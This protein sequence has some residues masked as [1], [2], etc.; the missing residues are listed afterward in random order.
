MGICFPI[1]PQAPRGRFQPPQ[2]NIVAK[3]ILGAVAISQ[4]TIF[5]G[6]RA[7]ESDSRC[8]NHFGRKACPTGG[9]GYWLRARLAT[10]R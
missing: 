5:A 4:R 9:C 7:R 6:N 3:T 8:T 10:G 1:G 2:S